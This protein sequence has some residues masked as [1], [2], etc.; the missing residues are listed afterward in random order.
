MVGF[1]VNAAAASVGVD[2]VVVVDVYGAV[3]VVLVVD[4]DWVVKTQ[5]TTIRILR[6][7]HV[8]IC[9]WSLIGKSYQPLN[10]I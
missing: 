6:M 3:V 8:F 1:V 4:D 9:S 2:A 7:L 5:K 10:M